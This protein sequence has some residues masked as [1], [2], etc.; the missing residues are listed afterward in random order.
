MK[1]AMLAI[2]LEEKSHIREELERRLRFYA[3]AQEVQLVANLVFMRAAKS[4]VTR[5][6]NLAIF[7][8]VPL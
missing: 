6:N 7:S 1:T 2:G 4:I 5:E 3:S 8:S